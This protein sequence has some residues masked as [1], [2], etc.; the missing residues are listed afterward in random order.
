VGVKGWWPTGNL[1]VAFFA[2][3]IWG[4]ILDA[5]TLKPLGVNDFIL[6]GKSSPYLPHA[7]HINIWI[8][9]TIGL[10][11]SIFFIFLQQVFILILVVPV[12]FLWVTLFIVRILLLFFILIGRWGAL[13]AGLLA[14]VHFDILVFVAVVTIH[15]IFSR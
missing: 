7:I 2:V 3:N 6:N 10:G 12:I 11:R 14:E 4:A 1:I 9:L 15:A 5:N 8:D 13:T